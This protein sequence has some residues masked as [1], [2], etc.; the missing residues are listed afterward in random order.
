MAKQVYTTGQILTAAQMTTLQANDYNQT[1]SA[2]TASYTLVAAD[3]GTRITMSNAGATAITVNTAVFTAGDT[4]EI[5][6]IGA[7]VCTVTAGTATV[8]TSSTLALKQYDS[9]QLYFTSTG[10]AIFFASDAADSPLTTKGD[11]FTFSTTND[12]LAVGSNGETL[13]ADSSTSTG[14]RYIP[15]FFAGKNKVINGDFGVWQRGTT[16]T[17]TTAASTFLA[18]RFVSR[19]DFSSGTATISQQTFTPGTAPVA[20]YENAYFQR[21]SIPSGA[22]SY[23]TNGTRIEDVRTFA[24]QTVTMS[25][26]AKSSVAQSGN[27]RILQ[28][29]G[30]G[31]SADVDNTAAISLTTSWARYT[32]TVTLGS[33]SGKTI[34]AGSYLQAAPFA[35][36]I[37]TSSSTIDLWGVQLEAGSGATSF[38]TATGTIQGEL[39]ACKYYYKRI[40][41][42]SGVGSF[43]NFGTAAQTT[44]ITTTYAD[45]LPMRVTPTSIDYANVAVS[46]INNARINASSVAIDTTF[47][48]SSTFVLN[49]AVTGATQYRP[50]TTLSQSAATGY[51]GLSAEL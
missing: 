24:G 37:W 20:G 42:G 5:T 9:G 1:V 30:S 45:T 19:F 11:L 33:M 8:S 50:Y 36:G 26:W 6:N 2:K 38:Q 18:D 51:I 21:L 4:L 46:D 48:T 28:S 32:M 41:G 17:S 10:V 15:T 25:F 31:G 16:T 40:T 14:L 12:R 29:F 44:Q 22:S 3:A 35:Y 13:V 49:L 47:S 34:G 23:M 7:G 27:M 43:T 39:A